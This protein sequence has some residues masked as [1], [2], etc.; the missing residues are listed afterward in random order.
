MRIIDANET[1][2]TDPD[3]TLGYTVADRVF[4]AHHD[5][6]EAVDEVSHTEVIA[7]YPNGGKDVRRVID[8][9]AVPA[10]EAWDEYEDVLRYIPYTEAELLLKEIENIKEQIR[11]YYWV[12]TEMQ[13][14][15]GTSDDYQKEISE[16]RELR[17]KLLEK[18]E[19]LDSIVNRPLEEIQNE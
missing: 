1:T 2:L 16:A 13:M 4:V 6:V 9:P 12:A 8:T 11:S 17:M 10:Q 5:A 18:S 14:G 15:L 19:E 3:M 7:E